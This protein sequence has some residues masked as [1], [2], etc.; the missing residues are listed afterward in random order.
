MSP[1]ITRFA[2]SPTGYLHIGG[3]RTA[4]FSWAFAKQHQGQFILRIEDTDTERS[5]DKH[6][7]AI[8]DAMEWVGIVPDAPPV[9]QS[10][11][12]SRHQTVIQQLLEQNHAYYCYTTAVELDKMRQE[13]TDRGEKPQ[14]NRYWRDNTS[15]PPTGIKPCIRFKIPL[16]GKTQFIDAIKG[17]LIID[18]KELD[19]FIIA[20]SDGTPT[21]NFAAVCDDIDM[22][23]SHIIRG[24]DHVMNTYRQWHI[25]NALLVETPDKMPVFAHL[26]MILSA[27]QNDTDNTDIKYERMSKRNAA[28]DVDIY[29]QDGI[30]P[31]ALINYLARLSWSHGD[32]EIFDSRFL[33][34]QF[35]FNA[36]SQ[37]PAR[38]DREKLN[39]VNREHLHTIKLPQIHQAASASII[40]NAKDIERNTPITLIDGLDGL[41]N[42][43]ND[44]GNASQNQIDDIIKNI[45]DRL[46][47][48]IDQSLKETLHSLLTLLN[49]YSFNN[50]DILE[51][52]RP[53]LN[54]FYDIAHEIHYF[55]TS[56]TIDKAV[57]ATH[58]NND[59]RVA[60][61][62][63]TQQLQQLPQW[64]A[65]A[66]KNCIKTTVKTH[67]LKFQ[68]L[69]MPMRFLLSGRS[70]S[71]DIASV[72]MQLGKEKTI[73]RL[74]YK[75]EYSF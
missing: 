46:A 60:F 30:V 39:W 41:F 49:I 59:N 19:D 13:Q 9:F 66:I 64:E 12:R 38:F 45:N 10:A 17:E 75:L 11:N 71:P 1:V 57:L 42:S 6:S 18:N 20:R 58:L 61:E 55:Y 21:Y 4:L 72:A 25:F 56:P 70:D 67:Q 74:Q 73:Q 7:Q 65:A 27:V 2:P 54:Q 22:K 33:I 43:P 14:Y 37:S 29:R 15:N 3:L 52:I 23:I 51:L 31:E 26:P 35:N 16:T 47:V 50:Q 24:D 36:I 53:R 40:K 48:P 44:L 62:Y 34:N 8:I 5:L 69:G 68:H 32:T 63:L 28:V